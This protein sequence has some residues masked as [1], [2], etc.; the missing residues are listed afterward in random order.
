MKLSR[1][2]TMV[3]GVLLIAVLAPLCQ[4]LTIATINSD[5]ETATPVGWAVGI[6][7]SIV[8]VMAVMRLLTRAKLLDRQNLV[9]LYC[10]LTIAV[11]VMNLGLVRQV[12]TSIHVVSREYMSLG[13]STY[14][15]AYNAENENW[16]PLVPTKYGLAWNKADRLLR[17]LE[18]RKAAT[19]R[20]LAKERVK[21]ALS[22]DAAS[23]A[24]MKPADLAELRM[25]VSLLGVDE[26]DAL[27]NLGRDEAMKQLGIADALK[28]RETQAAQD[29]AA[30]AKELSKL[31]DGYNELQASLLPDNL[32]RLDP[33]GSERLDASLKVLS[34]QDRRQ[35][36]ER[37]KALEAV[38]PRATADLAKLSQSDYR[39]VRDRLRDEYL[40]WFDTLDKNSL[41]SVR[42]DFVYRVTREERMRLTDLKG[43]NGEPNDYVGGFYYS[44]W[45]QL[46]EQQVKQRSSFEEN[47]Q[48]LLEHL[49]WGL[50]VRPMIMW[51]LL[52]TAIFLFLMCVAEWLRRKWIE[53]E[54]LAFPLVEVA[55]NILRHDYELETAVD[56]QNPPLR[57]LQ[58]NPLMLL[59]FGIGT[60]IL[61]IEA[62]AH[63]GMISGN[64]LISYDLAKQLFTTGVLKEWW[65]AYFV[66]SP[67]ILGIAFLV[68]LEISF[69]FWS[70]FLV[71]NVVVMV[72]KAIVKD[73]IR[74]SVYTGW[75]GGRFWPFPMD[76]MLGAV[77]CYSAI[78]VYKSLRGSKQASSGAAADYFIP[79]KLNFAGMVLLPA[80]IFAL[81]WNLG[82]HNVPMLVFFAL[83]M[84]AQTITEARLRAETG[85]HTHHVSYEFA[86]IPQVFG[87]SG[88]MGAKAYSIWASLTFL[89]MSL[90]GRTMPQHLENME[91]ARR[92]KLR[93]GHVAVSS[94]LAFL[95]ALAVGMVSFLVLTYYFGEKVWAGDSRFPQGPASGGG[96][97]HYP[98]WLSHFMGEE[99]LDKFTTL[100][101]IRMY[102]TMVGFGVVA[103]LTFLRGRFLRFPFHPI[104]YLLILMSIYY[105]WISPYFKGMESDVTRNISWL[106]GSVFAAWLIKKLIIKY[107]GMNA[108]KR[109]KPF[110]IGLVIGSVFC[111]F[112]WNV[113]DLV[114]S[115]VAQ[116][117]TDVPGTFVKFFTQRNPYSPRLY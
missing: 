57:K 33:K 41:D 77:L 9:V 69:S 39:S 113:T 92:N 104:G 4:F 26:V 38:A 90:L 103:L 28:Q 36:D 63:Y 65:A 72:I 76:Q 101:W 100:H 110:F 25:Q 71:F 111:I 64:G 54:N 79:P 89:P 11:P 18:D 75:G 74:D 96:I 10:M 37:V 116:N 55:D 21:A 78:M 87:L 51:G 48:Y 117:S 44:L 98:L 83:L 40:R 29:S 52:F 102:A 24:A 61:S 109:A 16:F 107:G 13:T 34:P 53:R 47:L 73:E 67:I 15:T 6:L 56:V 43:L 68:S 59:G 105:E 2:A 95:A 88:M 114:C 45:S 106:W 70:I 99:G 115:I 1:L 42:Q 66:L 60:L 30:A 85:L 94:L 84:M 23:I 91:L 108:Y 62:M 93:Y 82:I 19:V 81:M 112:A 80:G 86:K 3:L 20:E 22:L 97:A 14:R 27:R 46:Q 17:L 35:L 5:C 32:A 49:P 50:W 31:L 7:F 12:F 58:F 8:L